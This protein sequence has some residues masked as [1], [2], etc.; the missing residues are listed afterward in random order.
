MQQADRRG[1]RRLTYVVMSAL[2]AWHTF[3][4]I[5][6]PAPE[7]PVTDAARDL[8]QPYLT[9]FGLQHPWDF[10]APTVATGYHFSYVIEDTAGGKHT[11]RPGDRLNHL[12]P[13]AIW[14]K[15]HYNVIMSNSKSYGDAAVAAIC[16]EHASLN[17]VSVTLQ[18]IQQDEFWPDDWMNGKRPADAEFSTT[19]TLRT[20][21][22]PGR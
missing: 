21:T 11:F 13:T 9:L 2:V 18:E 10:F 12:Q 1:Y 8:A 3:A 19:K 22:C 20:I 16:L 15:D 4:M 7:S 17:P 6:G 5:I 14:M